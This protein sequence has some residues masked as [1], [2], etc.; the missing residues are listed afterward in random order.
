[1][2]ADAQRIIVIGAG[3]GGLAAA[4]GLQRRGFTVAVYERGAEIREFG[5]GVV[6]APNARRALRDLGVDSELERLSSSAPQ[7][8]TC[9]YATGE[10]VRID[11][12]DHIAEKHGMRVLQVHR[13]D[14]H[15]LLREAVRANDPEALRPGHTFVSLEQDAVGVTVHFANGASDRADA[16]IGADGNTS[17]VRSFLFPDEAPRFNG[18][19]AFRAL[20]PQELVPE[21]V[22]QRQSAMYPAPRRYLLHYPLRGGSLMNVI[23]CGQSDSW[24]EEGWSIPATNEE[25]AAHYA[26][27]APEVVELIRRIPEGALF[28]WGLRDR[29]PLARW[30]VGRVTMLGDAAH[31][32]TPFLG[33]GA[34]LAIEDSLLLGRAFA[35]A[36][37]VEEALARYEAARR[38]RG[39]NVQLWSREEGRALQ[40]P[41]IPRRT[42]LDRG[43]YDYDPATVP[44]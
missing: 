28:K 25:F 42:A 19:V 18:Q 32:M 11:R 15:G 37:T 20:V 12:N 7:M 24:H 27:L 38:P 1:M 17:A 33:Q 34:C 29:E 43:L 16:V 22:S 23:G 6:I 13:G 44:V 5:A 8:H 31:P 26:D 4:L 40:D 35:A 41:S 9:R 14:L 3:I 30:T 36:D 2:P 21:P 39:T 10:I